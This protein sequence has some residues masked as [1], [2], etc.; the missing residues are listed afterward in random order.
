MKLP[1]FNP[2]VFPKL[3]ERPWKFLAMLSFEYVAGYFNDTF[4]SSAVFPLAPKKANVTADWMETGE[5]MTLPVFP[6][7]VFYFK[8]T[9]L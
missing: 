7:I 8:I 6:S 4:I 5:M 2:L 3:S 9:K 1:I